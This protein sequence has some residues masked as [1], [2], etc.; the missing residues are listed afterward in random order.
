M[1]LVKGENFVFYVYNAGTWKL[2][3]CGRSGSMSINTEFLETTVTGS[4]NYRTFKPTVHDFT[5]QIDGIIALDEDTMMTL[6]D[7]E[8]LQ[9]A[10]TKILCRFTATAENSEVYT[11][12]CYF[13][14][15]NSTST[16]S[17]DGIATFQI[18]L[19]GTGSITQVFTPPP[20]PSGSDMR[21]PAQGDTAAATTGS[22]SWTATGLAGK[23][24]LS[25]VKDGRGSSNIITSGT[26]VGNEVLYEDSGADGLFTWAVPF[27]DGETPPYVVYRDI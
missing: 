16:G 4:G 15:S 11:K 3:A 5:G 12:E 7:L 25:V 22:Y 13:Y 27:E 23:Y 1:S 26:P 18:Q 2:Y 24:I 9:L 10:K 17:F 21:Y 20:A 14:I 6:S 8:A 19:R